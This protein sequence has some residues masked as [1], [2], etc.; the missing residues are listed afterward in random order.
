MA[1]NN[2]LSFTGL[3]DEQVRCSLVDLFQTALVRLVIER[4]SHNGTV[5]QNLADL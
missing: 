3:T 2:D 1:D 4:I 5:L